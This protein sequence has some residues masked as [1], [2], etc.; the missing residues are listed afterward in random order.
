SVVRASFFRE[1]GQQ[2]ALNVATH[3]RG[4]G[5][6]IETGALQAFGYLRQAGDIER[7]VYGAVEVRAQSDMLDPDLVGSVADGP[8][9]GGDRGVAHRG[10]PVADADH[11]AAGGDA[12]QVL[13]AEVACAGAGPFDS[14]VRDQYRAFGHGEYIIDQRA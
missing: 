14:G 13:V 9:D 3:D 4:D 10:D 6:V 12:L 2:Q 8:D 7:R 1:A 11:S 5:V